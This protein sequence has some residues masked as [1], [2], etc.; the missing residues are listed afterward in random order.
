MSRLTTQV[1]GSKTPP[2][3]IQQSRLQRRDI[4]SGRSDSRTQKGQVVVTVKDEG[5]AFRRRHWKIFGRFYRV[6]TPPPELAE[7]AWAVL[8][9]DYH[10]R[11]SVGG[12]RSQ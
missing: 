9:R 6:T 2:S 12:K 3:G 1:C 10:G 5:M 11:E 4:E 7:P 8:V